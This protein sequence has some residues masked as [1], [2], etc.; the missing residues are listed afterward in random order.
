M[1][2]QQLVIVSDAHL[3]MAPPG[4]EEAF[5][6]FLDA[7]PELGDALLVNGDLFHF[8]FSW[9][10][11]VPRGGLAT[12]MRLAALAKR[13]PVAL[14]GGNH[15]RWGGTFW[16]HDLGIR[17][18]PG[19]LRLAVGGTA[20]IAV[21]G[22]GVAEAHWRGRL[23]HRVIGGRFVPGVF[24]LLHPDAGMWLVDRLGGHLGDT[25]ADPAVLDEAAGRQ[26]AWAAA[27]L[28]AEAGAAL[29]VMGHTHRPA[30]EEPLP[31]RRY[32][33]PGAWLD[34]HRYAV[35]S[36]GGVELRRFQG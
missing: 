19:E 3:G 20:V 1:P 35:A 10:R 9:R 16:E 6:A 29:L 33:N 18:S 2:S 13:M 7:V 17:F 24:R 32:L 31:G 36:A 11:V 27:R 34:G 21:H 14:T 25:T 22:D 5:H 28:A 4:T 30:L 8:W 23:I 26:R 12:V 15:D